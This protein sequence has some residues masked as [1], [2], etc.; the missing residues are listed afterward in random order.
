MA[1][2]YDQK[3]EIRMAFDEAYVPPERRRESRVKFR[4]DAEICEWKKNHQGLPFSVRV[5]DFSP[6]GVGIQHGMPLDVGSEYL[7]RVPRPSSEEL[8]VLLTVAR[9][10]AQEDGTFQIGMEL[11]T[12]LDRSQMGKMIE[13]IQTRKRVTSRRTRVL[14]LLLGVC[15]LGTGLLIS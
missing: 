10:V 11:S 9:C 15:G 13:S 8:V 7:I 5:E 3:S 14:L 1:L 4:C 6:S 2:T 12:V